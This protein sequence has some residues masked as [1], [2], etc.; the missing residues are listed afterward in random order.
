LEA[1]QHFLFYRV[2]LLA[3]RPTSILEDKASVFITIHCYIFEISEL[4]NSLELFLF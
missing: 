1:S 2:G 3:P 4:L